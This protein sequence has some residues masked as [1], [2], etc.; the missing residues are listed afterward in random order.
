LLAITFQE[1]IV[2]KIVLA[3]ATVATLGLSTAAFAENPSPSMQGRVQLPQS[4]AT[5]AHKTRVSH[6]IEAKKVV[7]AHHRNLHRELSHPRQY[8][9]DS[10]KKNLVKHAAAKKTVRTKASS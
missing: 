2:N 3:L 10:V 6:R 8:G 9:Y 5:L 1:N 4:Q 7:L